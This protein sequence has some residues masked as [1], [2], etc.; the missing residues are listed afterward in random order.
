MLQDQVVVKTVVLTGVHIRISSPEIQIGQKGWARV[1]G[2]NENETPF[3]FAGAIYPLKFSWRISTPGII[4]AVSP[5]DVSILLVI[6]L[7]ILV[8]EIIV[9]TL[10]FAGFRG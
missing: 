4:K 3:S 2:L 9:I 6:Y 8:E 7:S 5:V 10:L 1:D